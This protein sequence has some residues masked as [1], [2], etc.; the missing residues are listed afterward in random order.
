MVKFLRTFAFLLIAWMLPGQAN[1]LADSLFEAGQ[2]A[3]KGGDIL[4][5]YILY[6]R[7]AALDPRNLDFAAKMTALGAVA[8]MS[9][10]E[11]HLPDPQPAATDADDEDDDAQV[12]DTSPLTRLEE[13]Q[14]REA[15]PPVRL[16]ASPELL[17]FNLK[18]DARTIFEKVGTAYDVNIVFE[19]D[20]QPGSQFTFRMTEVGYRDA[21]RALET[22][23]GSFIVAIG[24][25]VAMVVKDTPQKR[26]EREPVIATTIQLPERMTVQDSQELQQAVTATMEIRRIVLDPNKHQMVLRDKVSKVLAAEQLIDSLM[27]GRPTVEIELQ[28]VETSKTSSL[29]YG[30]NLPNEISLVNFSN[31]LHNM[32]SLPTNTTSF[33]SFGGG[34]TMFGLG[35]T[36]ASAF[37]TVAKSSSNNLLTSRITAI[38]GQATQLLVGQHYP[39]ITNQYIGNTL[40]ATGIGTSGGIFTPPPTINFEDLGLVLKITPSVHSENE[41]T[42]DID[43]SYKVLGATDPNTGIPIISTRHYVGKVRV[44]EGEW[45]VL[46]G[47]VSTN[48]SDSLTGYPGI[49]NIPFLRRLLGQSTIEKDSDDVLLVLKPRL[50]NTPAWEYPTRTIWVGTDT[51]PLTLF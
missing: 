2:Q 35:V 50:L 9:V 28:L 10:K 26:N 12:A 21:L 44:K 43:A 38:D 11:V 33:L 14:A 37:A 16:L 17:S 36:N 8:A 25:K 48:N 22:L 31:I 47:L 34:A 4:H 15:L 1:D 19:A 46:A 49:S 45:A 32:A 23:T 40:G 27:H 5:A 24:P 20:Y 7:A 29:G 13:K 6:S 39:I 3:E 41:M 18:G 42:L 51:R 30:L